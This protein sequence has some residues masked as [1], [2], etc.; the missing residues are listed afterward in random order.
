MRYAVI[1]SLIAIPL[2]GPELVSLAG[3]AL[4]SGGTILIPASIAGLILALWKN[5]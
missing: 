4:S 1:G 5:R 2:F 3:S